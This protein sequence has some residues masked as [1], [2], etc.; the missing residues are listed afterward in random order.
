MSLGFELVGDVA[1]KLVLRRPGEADVS[2]VCLRR[3]FPWSMPKRHISIRSS[4]GKEI[5]HVD[6]LDEVEPT[7]RALIER[8]LARHSFI[9]RITRIDRV[10]VRFGHQLWH[11]QTQQGPVEF[12]VQERE[13]IRFLQDGR[14]SIKDADGNVYELPALHNLDSSSRRA[15]EPL[16]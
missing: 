3:S 16:L 4:D 2:D 8:W 9:P 7:Q 15:V 12:R 11:V 1:G 5:V 6:S 10:D 13:D 14:F